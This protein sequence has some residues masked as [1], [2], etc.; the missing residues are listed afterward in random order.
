MLK[1][2]NLTVKAGKKQLLKKINYHFKPNKVYFIMGPNG[3][4][5]STFSKAILGLPQYKIQP[6]TQ[7]LFKNKDITKSSTDKRVQLGLVATWQS[8]L[9]LT[10]VTVQQLL[11]TS[12]SSLKDPFQVQEELTILA[13]ELKIKTALLDR[14][15]NEGASGGEQKKLEVLQAF[16]LDPDLI[17]FDEIDTGVDID[18]L[19]TVVNFIKKYRDKRTYIFI[20][21]SKSITK[22]IK[23]DSVLVFKNGQIVAEDGPELVEKIEK[24]GFNQ[25]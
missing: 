1:I 17:I 14:P 16:M 6:S 9:S 7:I 8:P 12:L 15:L 22:Y 11:Q 24:Q 25:F 23:P 21:H 20:T 10:G 19:K 18:S 13:K 4:G 2:K 3:S 5:K